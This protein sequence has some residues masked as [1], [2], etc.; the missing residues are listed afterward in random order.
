SLLDIFDA[1]ETE[2]WTATGASLAAVN[3]AWTAFR[4]G[5]PPRLEEEMDRLLALL[6]AAIDAQDAN[7][8]RQQSIATARVAYDFRLRHE[9]VIDIDRVRFD[10]WLAQV[11]VDTSTAAVGPIKGDVSTLEL[12][13]NRIAHTFDDGTATD[14]EGQLAD[15]RSAA[16]AE[17][18]AQASAA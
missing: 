10:L 12:V 7:E 8:A 11:S 2:D 18:V 6:T 3:A 17:D 9:P 15:L 4:A 13:W 16:D 14:I 1:V 5:S